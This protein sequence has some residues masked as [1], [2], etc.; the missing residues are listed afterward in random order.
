MQNNKKSLI[1]ENH[2]PAI[3]TSYQEKDHLKKKIFNF[4]LEKKQ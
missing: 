3:L 4:N 2:S 1:N